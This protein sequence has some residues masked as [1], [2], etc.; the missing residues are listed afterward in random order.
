TEKCDNELSEANAES[1]EQSDR[2]GRARP[3]FVRTGKRRR[4][5]KKWNTVSLPKA[6]KTKTSNKETEA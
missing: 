3:K 6:E 2:V 5:R 4:H 1:S